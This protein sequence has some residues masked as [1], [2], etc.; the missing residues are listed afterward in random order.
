M[1]SMLQI[2]SETAWIKKKD[3][4]VRGVIKKFVAWC[5]EINTYS[6]VLTNFVGDIKQQMLYQ[7]W[8]FKLDVL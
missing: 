2:I 1:E 3:A 7:V 5:D 6:A 4:G 8:K